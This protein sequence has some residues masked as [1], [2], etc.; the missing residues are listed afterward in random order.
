MG[1]SVDIE[2]RIYEHFRVLSIGSHHCIALQRAYNKYGNDSFSH[3]VLSEC[4]QD[5]LIKQE[6][7]HID[8][9]SEYNSSRTAGSPL[10]TKHTERTR[11]KY[12]ER[13]LAQWA[14]DRES[15]SG[16]YD[17]DFLDKRAE[18]ISKAK[19][20]KRNYNEDPTIY[21][22]THPEYGDVSKTQKQMRYEFNLLK[23]NVNGLIKGRQKSCKGWRLKEKAPEGA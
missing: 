5:D 11:K 1:S 4:H 6:Q 15:G 21:H 10:G 20:S 22:F 3:S 13:M 7:E 19:R 23:A 12:S 16:F 14:V 8:H 2:K 9:R 17:R 18:A